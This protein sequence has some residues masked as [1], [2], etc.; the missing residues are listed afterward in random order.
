MVS[1]PSE[2]LDTPYPKEPIPAA[3]NE[4]L[5]IGDWLS[6]S[7]VLMKGIEL[8]FSFNPGEE[9]ARWVAGDWQ[10]VSKAASALDQLAEYAV[11][12]GH[13]LDGE[14]ATMLE[15]WQG[16]A[17]TSASSYFEKLAIAV[18]SMDAALRGVSDEYQAVAAGM[19]EMATAVASILEQLLDKLISMGVKA[20]AATALSETVIGGVVFGGWAAYDAYRATRL[21]T[22]ALEWHGRA[23][24]AS[25]ALVGLTAGYLGALR[26]LDSVTLPNSYDHPGA[27]R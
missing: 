2:V 9:A 12:L 27:Q 11:R 4:V 8:V 5:G 21:W 14:S 19:Q 23:L 15:Q 13:L 1:L 3:L 26:D 18:D 10:S 22:Q 17:A 24:T 25:Q 20:L 7:H 16:N 6:P